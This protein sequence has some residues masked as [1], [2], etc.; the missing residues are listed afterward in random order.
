MYCPVSI[1]GINMMSPTYSEASLIA[2]S[3]GVDGVQQAE[4]KM[5]NGLNAERGTG[6]I[7]LLRYPASSEEAF[8]RADEFIPER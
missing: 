8:T 7:T 6:F 3:C 4:Y 5:K 2:N 1:S